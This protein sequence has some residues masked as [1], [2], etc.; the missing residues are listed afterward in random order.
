MKEKLNNDK[1][2]RHNNGYKT[3][4]RKWFPQIFG[5]SETKQQ[6]NYNKSYMGLSDG[7]KSRNFIYFQPRKQYT[8]VYIEVDEKEEW[9][10]KLDEVGIS[11]SPQKTHLQVTLTPDQLAKEKELIITLT[12]EAVQIYDGD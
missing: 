4:G 3:T 9:V 2:R 6:L 1:V 12:Q 8:H 5:C 11:A 7:I 10:R